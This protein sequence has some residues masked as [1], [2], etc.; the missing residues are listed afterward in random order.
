MSCIGFGISDK[1]AINYCPFVVTR[2][3]GKFAV[4][5]TYRGIGNLN[6]SEIGD[7]YVPSEYSD[8]FGNGDTVLIAVDCHSGLVSFGVN[9][10]MFEEK[11]FSFGKFKHG[12]HLCVWLEKVGD[13]V[14]LIA[15]E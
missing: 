4:F 12:V 14:Q 9:N 11:N 3:F 13:E 10:V 6:F 7:D 8:G 15:E 1:E 2:N 5:Y